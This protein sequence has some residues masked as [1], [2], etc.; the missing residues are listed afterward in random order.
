MGKLGAR[1]AERDGDGSR[2]PPGRRGSSRGA[3]VDTPAAEPD[4]LEVSAYMLAELAAKQGQAAFDKYL[5]ALDDDGREE[6]RE[7]MPEFWG[8]RPTPTRRNTKSIC[9]FRRL[10]WDCL[11]LLRNN[12]PTTPR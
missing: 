4:G 5:A 12:E 3:A 9:H 6:V 7:F 2:R 8:S 10:T 1:C 11:R